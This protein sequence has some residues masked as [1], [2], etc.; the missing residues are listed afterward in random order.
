MRKSFAIPALTILASLLLPVNAHALVNTWSE[1]VVTPGTTRWESG[2]STGFLHTSSNA[3]S[4]LNSN[5]DL[6]H[7]WVM[8]IT[9]DT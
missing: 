9:L 4:G 3:R 5:P 7:V 8:R 1:D 6:A 2:S